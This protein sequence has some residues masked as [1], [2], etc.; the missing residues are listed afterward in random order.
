MSIDLLFDLNREVRR[1]FIAGSGMAAG[2]FNLK[3][4]LPQ[5]HKFGE[6][7][8]VFKRIAQAVEE[9]LESNREDG[10]VKLLDLGTL[11]T[12]VLYTQGKTEPQTER[13]AIA[14][15]QIQIG[16][17]IPYRK[18]QPLI[19]AL[20][21][22]GSGRWEV[23]HQAHEE[24]LFN[25]FRVMFSA[26]DALDDGYSEIADF[27]HNQVL[28]A[29]GPE[30]LP[31]LHQQ[32]RQQGGKGDA[33]RL[34]HIYRLQQ[35]EGLDLYL[36]AAGEGSVEV[37][38]AA[39]KILGHFADQES[40]ILEQADDKKKEIREAAYHA[41]STLGTE[42][43]LDRL[44]AVLKSKDREMAVEPIRRS[45]SFRLANQVIAHADAA[46]ER[47]LVS[48]AQ[49]KTKVTENEADK[50][51]KK[52]KNKELEKAVEELHVDL[53]S[54]D[55]FESEEVYTLLTK[56]LSTP[57]FVSQHTY[58]LQNMAV[59]MLQNMQY[60]EALPFVL[61]LQDKHKKAFICNS[62]WAAFKLLSPADVY[63]RFA[64]EFEERSRKTVKELLDY[65]PRIIPNMLRQLNADLEEEQQWTQNWDA[66]W[67]DLFMKMN[68][69]DLV[70]RL[71][72]G[73]ATRPSSTVITYLIHKCKNQL[74]LSNDNTA[75]ML[76]TLLKLGH[77]EAPDLVMEA[78][79]NGGIKRYYYL[80]SNSLLFH[81]FHM[82][83]Y[84]Y[85]DQ[86]EHFAQSPKG[87]RFKEQL[88]EIVE[89]LRAKQAEGTVEAQKGMSV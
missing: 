87:E 58:W 83:P 21:T 86:L 61:D 20:N 7:A 41:L 70:C 12:S 59:N 72:Y 24:G 17:N 64:P 8:A 52:E 50:E 57:G 56:L 4:I 66:R 81:L 68:Q 60:S 85:A 2:D 25:D 63:E 22:K 44:F 78:L 9:V 11:L 18:L 31:V 55:G 49:K 53:Q 39:I 65:I 51:K 82:L 42:Q 28:L 1:L 5:L 15:T 74:D 77:E 23:I 71:V 46:F 43:A 69:D 6:S 30:I 14:G 29:Y 27:I 47:I 37:R 33:R 79:E 54:L 73:T 36:A 88:L 34:E 80:Y 76:I 19:E 16:T 40:F 13:H 84:T 35:E 38:A 45:S 10:A 89:N 75:Q 32:F 67:I 3:K 62:L 48:L 26:V